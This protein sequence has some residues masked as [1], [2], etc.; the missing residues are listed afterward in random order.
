VLTYQTKHY[1]DLEDTQCICHRTSR[2]G[3]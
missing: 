3:I 2:F 1:Y